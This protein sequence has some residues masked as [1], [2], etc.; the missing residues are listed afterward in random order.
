MYIS[1][2]QDKPE[3][4]SP[5]PFQPKKAT[6][7][8]ERKLIPMIPLMQME[9]L[10]AESNTFSKFNKTV[11]LIFDNME[12]IDMSELEAGAGEHDASADVQLPQEILINKFQLQGSVGSIPQNLGIR[13]AVS[14]F[15]CSIHLLVMTIGL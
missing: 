8:I 5:E 4:Q 6:R 14:Q 3:S 2:F 15:I 13:I 11:E 10:M 9:D 1:S 12:D 7:K